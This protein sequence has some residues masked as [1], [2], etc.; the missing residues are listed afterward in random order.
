MVHLDVALIAED[1][2]GP[3]IEHQHA[4]RH[5]VED[6]VEQQLLIRPDLRFLART[7]CGSHDG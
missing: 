3:G 2:A 5:V 7:F 1:H 4:L 6:G